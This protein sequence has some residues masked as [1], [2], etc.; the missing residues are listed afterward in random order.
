MARTIKVS[1]YFT[2]VSLLDATGFQLQQG[3]ALQVEPKRK[4]LWRSSMFSEGRVLAYDVPENVIETY[5]VNLVG[6]SHDNMATQLQKLIQLA[7]KARKRHT[8]KWQKEDVY[9]EVQTTGETNTRYALVYDIHISF[10]QSLFDPPMDPGNR[11]NSIVIKVE[12]EPYWRGQ[13]PGTRDNFGINITVDNE[14]TVVSST[15]K[16]VCNLKNKVYDDISHIYAYDASL[17]TF[18]ANRIASSTWDWFRVSATPAVGDMM[19]IGSATPW[20]C[21][22]FRA[23]ADANPVGLTWDVEYYNGSWTAVTKDPLD[24]FL[25]QSPVEDEDIVTLSW[26]GR[27]DWTTTTINGQD[28]YWVR[29]T[30]TAL[31]FCTIWPSQDGQVPYQINQNYIKI[32]ADQ[33]DG[34]VSAIPFFKLRGH[35]RDNEVISRVFVGAK[36]RGLTYFQSILTC[37][38]NENP[39][40]TGTYGTDTANALRPMAGGGGNTAKCTFATDQTM[41]NRYQFE[42]DTFISNW[43][44]AYEVFVVG[45]QVGGS[46]GDVL[47]RFGMTYFNTTVDSKIVKTTAVAGGGELFHMGR[48]TII[49]EGIRTPGEAADDNLIFG[50]NLQSDNGTTPDFYIYRLVFIPVDEW[51]FSVGTNLNVINAAVSSASQLFIDGGLIEPGRVVQVGEQLGHLRGAWEFRGQLPRIEPDIVTH[52]YFLF[53]DDTHA[54]SSH[55]MSVQVMLHE[56]WAFLRGAD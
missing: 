8:T 20:H 48:F 24:K 7:S 22:A 38:A 30:I 52:I 15:E 35:G 19:Y 3:S 33:I 13:R 46:A 25:L 50:I 34:D 47:I 37:A 28:L 1:D 51:A 40:F 11:V 31:T 39:Y 45:E 42:C 26:R 44:G 53:A 21:V 12:R 54:F 16:F 36:T 32:A 9:L 23:G 29:I 5:T 4:S 10:D 27:S 43:E 56:R 49:P 2:S 55:A 6:T 17:T 18:S 41:E 14:P